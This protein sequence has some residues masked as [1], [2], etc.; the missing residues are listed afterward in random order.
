M[1]RGLNKMFWMAVGIVSL[2]SSCVRETQTANPPVSGK[3]A[4]V[5][6]ETRAIGG[7][8]PD[9]R[10]VSVRIMTFGPVGDFV[11][12]NTFYD[13]AAI[14]A[15][16][17]TIVHE[18]KSGEQDF[19]F[20]ANENNG[21]ELAALQASSF[22][23]KKSGLNGIS[24]P[25]SAFNQ[26]DPI[27]MF[28]GVDNVTV[29]PGSEGIRV[30]GGSI[31][32]S[33]WVVEM[34]RLAIRIDMALKSKANLEGQFKG[35]SFPNAANAVPLTGN[36]AGGQN[37]AKT[38]AVAGNAANFEPYV[39]TQADID[40]GYVWGKKVTRIILPSHTFADKANTAK[41]LK[42][43]IIMDGWGANPSATIGY[44]EPSDNTLPPNTN[45]TGEGIISPQLQLN[46]YPVEWTTQDADGTIGRTLNVSAI[47]KYLTKGATRRIY[48][49]SNQRSVS[50]DATGKYTGTGTEFTVSAVFNGLSDSNFNYTYDA[51]TGTGTGYFDITALST[52][53][54]GTYSIYLNAGG[55]RREIP[56][57][58]I[59][60][61]PTIAPS[62]VGTFHRWNETGERLLKFT[63]TF[64]ATNA[65]TW[66]AMV[67]SGEEWIA[68]DKNPSGGG[69]AEAN[70]L[71]SG[72]SSVSGTCS[73][74]N[75]IY[76]RVGMRSRLP[77]AES[78]PRYGLVMLVCNAGTAN[79]RSYLIYVR[80]GEAADYLMRNVAEDNPES[81]PMAGQKRT[82][83][84]RISPYNLTDPNGG[85]GRVG[86]ETGYRYG[87]T[88][89]PSKGGYFFQW[90]KTWAWSPAGAS[91]TD[92]LGY[93]G[94]T[95]M[96]NA[97][98]VLWETCPAGYR[99]PADGS[100]TSSVET[101]TAA[102]SE[103]RQSLYLNPQNDKE[104]KLD[105]S[106]WG[107][108]ADGFF[109]RGNIVTPPGNNFVANTAVSPGTANAA[110]I[111]RL[112]FNS[113]NN[114]SVF[115]PAPGY[116]YTDNGVLENAGGHGRYWTSTSS[117]AYNGWYFS[118]F[119]TNANQW[120][121][122]RFYGFLIRCVRD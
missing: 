37:T 95:G 59:L 27:P 118:V 82:L 47:R 88:D 106:T 101:P 45:F 98:N 24:L 40:A 96:W 11:S 69:T 74:A 72:T 116:R 114:A 9:D 100:T 21:A 54:G 83:A 6:I 35:V 71:T 2:L 70:Q 23:G 120:P 75:P 31:V 38:V 102:A 80:Q 25:A 81:G 22:T 14:T 104:S 77:S 119:D 64:S 39:L 92:W 61:D 30:E 50:I 68:L 52:A 105:N 43:E 76:F 113:N 109:D 7:S 46:L 112:F 99:R 16:G 20:I 85:S 117:S 89:Y 56:V 121:D 42:M 53:K 44:D 4:L 79:H 65:G 78:A 18:M 107:F 110:Y 13:E 12:S 94:P 90:Y 63:S 41:A 34:K 87:F 91:T 86:A 3:A 67:V 1:K 97:N 15:A 111:G 93:Y 10:I 48:F 55:L 32:T 49:N 29:L 115:L 36:Y 5:K 58:L 17:G 62:Y 26:T 51:A 33:D 73:S 122:V 8:G 66:T 84:V 60:A 28:T 19:V 108:L 57:T 103:I